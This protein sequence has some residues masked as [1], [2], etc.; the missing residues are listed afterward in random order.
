MN[1]ELSVIREKMLFYAYRSKNLDEIED[2][3]KK[4]FERVP[5]AYMVRS[6]FMIRGSFANKKKLVISR[7]YCGSR[8]VFVPLRLNKEQLEHSISMLGEVNEKIYVKRRAEERAAMLEELNQENHR[9]YSKHCTY[10]GAVYITDIIKPH[11]HCGKRECVSA[12]QRHR[13]MEI[14]LR[15]EAAVRHQAEVRKNG[16]NSSMPEIELDDP[17]TSTLQGYVYCIRAANGL[18]KIGRSSN[19]ADRFATVVTHSPIDVYL[20]HTVFSDNYVLAEGYAHNKLNQY[21]HHGEWYDL[22]NDVYDWFLT[23]DNYDLDAN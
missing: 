11:P 18:C 22:P 21:H 2:A 14:K 20:E 5:D 19:V 1:N 10:C 7:K 8:A 17:S 4:R 15:R 6:P 9:N 16:K 13:E 23:L 12:H 3:F